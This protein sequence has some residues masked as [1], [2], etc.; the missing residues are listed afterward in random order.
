MWRANGGSG[1]VSVIRAATQKVVA[2][3]AAGNSPFGA[4]FI[5]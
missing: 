2:T 5:P 3:V 1:N 4:G